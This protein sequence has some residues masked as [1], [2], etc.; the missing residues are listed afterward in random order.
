MSHLYDAATSSR[1]NFDFDIAKYVTP[2]CGKIIKEI[3]VQE[4]LELSFREW[5]LPIVVVK[6]TY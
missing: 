2:L 3:W 6:R 1:R 4:S 5:I